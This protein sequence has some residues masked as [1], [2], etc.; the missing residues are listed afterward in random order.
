[1]EI[2]RY[3]GSLRLRIFILLLPPLVAGAV[4]F[5]MSASAP[6]EYRAKSTVTAP[7]LTGSAETPYTGLNG[8]KS[9]VADLTALVTSDRVIGSVAE[10]T[11]IP[12]RQIAAGLSARQLG[13]S[14]LVE[15]TFRTARKADAEP[16]AKAAAYEAVRLLP[17]SQL[18]VAGSLVEQAQ[19]AV[20]AAQ[21]EL[22]AFKAT[23]GL[24]VPDR[25]Y[26]IKAQQVSELEQQA[27][28]ASARGDAPTAAAINAALPGKRK[29]LAA[30]APKLA[31][32]SALVD[33]RDRALQQL[34]QAQSTLKMAT[35]IQQASDPATIVSVGAA[36]AIPRKQDIL[37]KT[38]VAVGAALFLA[39]GLLV[40]IE[41][42]RRP[43]SSAAAS[44][45]RGSD[46]IRQ[47]PEVIVEGA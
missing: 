12:G 34:T 2:S 33:K 37:Q 18:G 46:G 15:V 14:S 20:D 4:V 26:Q 21:K 29:E 22:D 47:K 27:L 10:T 19:T 39:I 31:T 11:G 3:I 23:S 42:T 6:R 45:P 24:V 5:R 43:K 17:G 44:R 1:M 8:G 35:A 13:T 41:P 7:A 25:D 32:Y 16:V 40:L 9:F 30:L 28:Q 36:R 38:G